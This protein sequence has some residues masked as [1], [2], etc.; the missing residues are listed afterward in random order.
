MRNG[1]ARNGT[2]D[3][4][5]NMT[6]NLAQ[7]GGKEAAAQAAAAHDTI[8]Q[9]RELLF[10]HEKRRTDQSLTELRAELAQQVDALRAEMR[11]QVDSLTARLIDLEKTT[12]QRRLDAI[13]DIGQAISQLGAAIQNMG[14][15][16]S[17][18]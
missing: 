6:Q 11:Q 18:R 2:Q 8:D 10:G 15:D 1:Q 13:S 9:V 3:G 12:E 4:A 7:D 16:K 14:A 17:R 5:R